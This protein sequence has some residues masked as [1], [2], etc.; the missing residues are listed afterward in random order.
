MII[1][2]AP[3][4]DGIYHTV[5]AGET[6]WRICK[7]YGADLETVK[8]VNRIQDVTNI[9]IGQR[10]YIPKA[11]IEDDFVTLYPSRKWKYI[12][13]HHS[14]TDTGDLE[15]IDSA[16]RKRGWA[17]AGY[18][19]VIDNGTCGK[20][21]GQIEATPRW[22]AQKDGAHCRAGEMNTR[23]IGI[24]LVGNYSQDYPSER[25]LEALVRLVKRLES[26][27]RI[28]TSRILG[29]RQVPGAKT[30]CPGTRFPWKTFY[31]LLLKQD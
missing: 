3:R 20:S 13:I 8:R 12:V 28:P 10:I 1:S 15:K 29:H 14:A 6:L 16:H 18:H 17:G 22:K 25:Q 5:G 2:K 4:L 31:G 30:E 9:E 24:C 7:T 11:V 21:D 26:F 19:F 23:G 27:Y